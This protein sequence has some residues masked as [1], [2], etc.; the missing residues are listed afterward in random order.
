IHYSDNV[1]R[2]IMNK[3]TIHYSSLEISGKYLFASLEKYCTH[4]C[5]KKVDKEFLLG[6]LVEKFPIN[7][8]D[9]IKDRVLKEVSPA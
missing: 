2:L 9:F 7:R 3:Q 8:L 4:I 5:G 1:S 6:S